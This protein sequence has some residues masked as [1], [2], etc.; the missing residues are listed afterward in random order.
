M[1]CRYKAPWPEQLK[2]TLACDGENN[3][4]YTATRNDDRLNFTTLKCLRYGEPMLIANL[5]LQE[6][7]S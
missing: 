6:K 4:T 5:L 3:K 2:Y 7:L 1:Q